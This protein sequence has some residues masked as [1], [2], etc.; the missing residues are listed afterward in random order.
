MNTFAPSEERAQELERALVARDGK[1]IG[2]DEIRFRC[3]VHSPDE[4][5]SARYNRA[6]HVWTCDT[7]KA[8]GGFIDLARRLEIEVER[9]TR[10][11]SSQ[12]VAT[13]TYA[14]ERGETLFEVV[15]SA[16]KKFRQRRPDGQG[17]HI[18]NLDG[19][20]RVLYDLP[21]VLAW[22]APVGAFTWSKAKRMLTRSPRWASWAPPRPAGQVSGLT[23]TPMR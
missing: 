3:P 10:K 1:D 16:G 20:R 4:H 23:N 12:V 14:D 13:Y 15:R 8:G 18:W 2:R 7:C 5:P 17:G 9:S 6:M 11:E 21:N 22:R 19:V